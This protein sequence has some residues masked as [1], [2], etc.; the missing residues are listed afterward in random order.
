MNAR[1][2]MTVREFRR[3]QHPVYA[4]VSADTAAGKKDE[5]TSL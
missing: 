3:I 4:P 5:Q 2:L 1:F